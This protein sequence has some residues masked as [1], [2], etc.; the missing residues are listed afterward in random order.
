[1]NTTTTQ[2]VA[3][4]SAMRGLGWQGEVP[5]D[6][7]LKDLFRYFNVVDKSDGPRLEAIGYNLP[8]LSASDLVALIDDRNRA[9]WYLCAGSGWVEITDAQA[10]TYMIRAQHDTAAGKPGPLFARVVDKVLE[11]LGPD[12]KVYIGPAGYVALT[13]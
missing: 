7:S 5:A 4:F 10:Q 2:T 12:T 3:V 13:S 8:S 9:T 11:Y 1:M 6:A